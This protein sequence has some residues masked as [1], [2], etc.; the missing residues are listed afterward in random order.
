VPADFRAGALER[1]WSIGNAKAAVLP[2]PVWAMPQRSRPRITCGIACDWIGVGTV[3]PSAATAWRMRGASPKW[4]KLDKVVNSQKM[5]PNRRVAAVRRHLAGRKTTRVNRV[6]RACRHK[7]R[8]HFPRWWDRSRVFGHVTRGRAR[9]LRSLYV[10]HLANGQGAGRGREAS[11]GHSVRPVTSPRLRPRWGRA[12][13]GVIRRRPGMTVLCKTMRIDFPRRAH[14][15]LSAHSAGV[16]ARRN[17]GK[18]MSSFSFSKTTS[19]RRPTF[20]SVYSASIRLPARRAP[21]ASSS[22]TIMLA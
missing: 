17:C 7:D 5:R 21:G 12:G 19:T 9:T 2:V 1:R 13:V 4:E 6:V 22:S 20:A 14:L 8:T 11:I 16:R 18:V 3:Y 15:L 10:R